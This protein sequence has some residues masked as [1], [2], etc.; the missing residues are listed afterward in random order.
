M[1]E[2]NNESTTIQDKFELDQA[3]CEQIAE[4]DSQQKMINVALSSLL[5]YVARRNKLA[6]NW[7][8][9]ENRRELIRDTPVPAQIQNEG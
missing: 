8:L 2:N 3:A 9:A 7:K 1:L 6:G 4:L 5:Q